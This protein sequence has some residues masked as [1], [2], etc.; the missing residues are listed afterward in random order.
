MKKQTWLK[1]A[2]LVAIAALVLSG[3]SKKDGSG[4]GSSRSSGRENPASDFSYDLTADGKG[5]LI[6]G[7]TGGAGRVVVPATIEDMPVLEI[8]DGA[9]DGKSMTFS[10]SGVGTNNVDY[11]VGSKAN[12]KA[13]ITS[14][15]I[16]N[17][18]RKIG[19]SAFANTAIT[20][21][22]MPDSVTELGYDGIGAAYIFSGCEQLTEIRFSDNIECIPGYLF[23]FGSP[24]A[25][26][27]INLPKNLKMIGDFTFSNAGELTE[28]V[29]PDTLTSV[30]FVSFE[31]GKRVKHPFQE[32]RPEVE[33]W[34]IGMVGFDPKSD[35]SAFKDSGK[36][37]IKTRQTLQG[38]G[39]T[40]GF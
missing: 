38:W 26:R 33:L 32:G 22:D 12:E 9:F 27:K 30:E 4:G 35:N 2:A 16:P 14:I 40:S 17:T 24:K 7:Y 19:T 36:L 29:I 34:G 6:K 13:G 37:P 11:S 18:V 15:T 1:G 21:F 5:I 8:G 39:Y 10:F 28:I 3:C 23:G 31:Q 25:L 20:R